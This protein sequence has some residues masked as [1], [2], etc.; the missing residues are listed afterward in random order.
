LKLLKDCLLI[1]IL[2]T[3]EKVL[4]LSPRELDLLVRQ[5]R[6]AFLLARLDYLFEQ[7]DVKKQLPETVLRHLSSATVLSNKQTTAVHWEAQCL[8]KALTKAEIRP[9]L[10]KGGA[11]V[12]L[13]LPPM[14]GRIF[15]DI[16]IM[17]PRA[18]LEQ[19]E[20]ALI[21]SGWIR[22]ALDKYDQIYYRKWMHEVPPLISR[23]R[24]T[25]TDLHHTIL[26]PTSRLKVKTELLFEQARETDG[27]LVLA[28]IDMVLHSATH[29][30]C[31]GEL[32]HGLRDLVD[33]DALLRHFGQCEAGFWE[34]LVARSEELGLSRPLFYALRYSVLLL[35]TPVPDEVVERASG[36]APIFRR[37]MDF[38]FRRALMPDHSSCN[39]SLTPVARWFLY[40]RSHYLRMPLFLLVPHLVRKA[41]KR[42]ISEESDSA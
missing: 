26:P 36:Y 38:Q 25:V 20:R 17:A 14:H 15:S 11:Y 27:A 18:Q 21:L 23:K 24:Q 1:Q 42:R 2:V 29:L 12:Y 10:L 31:D 28:P 4:Q 13:G 40:V 33:L 39:D 41:W 34:N 22:K 6:H 5:A 37:V 7:K 19:A 35:K 3:P 16:D 9:V 8:K 30:F 32:E